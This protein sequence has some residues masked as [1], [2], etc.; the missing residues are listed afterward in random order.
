MAM[1]LD[2]L[3]TAPRTSGESDAHP[4]SPPSGVPTR[5]QDMGKALNDGIL[6]SEVLGVDALEARLCIDRVW[7]LFDL[8]PSPCFTDDDLPVLLAWLEPVVQGLAE[9]L[10]EYGRAA[11]PVGDALLHSDA[12]EADAAGTLRVRGRYA[13]LRNLRADLKDFSCM[14]DWAIQ[15]ALWIQ[16]EER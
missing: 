8:V 10:D 12:V 13:P 16:M 7:Q 5:L 14:V 9:G 2:L 3:L 1:S 11:G 15:S 6:L 4:I